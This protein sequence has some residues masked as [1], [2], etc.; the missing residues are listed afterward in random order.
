MQEEKESN[1]G[2]NTMRTH[3]PEQIEALMAH[4]A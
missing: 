1:N 4:F 3:G 2:G